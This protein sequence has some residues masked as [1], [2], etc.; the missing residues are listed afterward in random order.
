MNK[1]VR[2]FVIATS[3]IAAILAIGTTTEMMNITPANAMK[4]CKVQYADP[5]CDIRHSRT[6]DSC[7]ET[8]R[9]AFNP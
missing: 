7:F 6:A 8:D 1:Q 4:D 2:T 9:C 3:V 5:G